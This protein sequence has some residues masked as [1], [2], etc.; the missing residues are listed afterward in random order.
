[1]MGTHSHEHVMIAIR[2][3]VG[4]RRRLVCGHRSDPYAAGSTLRRRLTSK[5][6][7]HPQPLAAE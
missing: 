4:N 6:G 3:V 2:D 5:S 7:R 1:M